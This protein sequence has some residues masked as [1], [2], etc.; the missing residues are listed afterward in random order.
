MTSWDDKRPGS[1]GSR[2]SVPRAPGFLGHPFSH[3]PGMGLSDGPV[4]QCSMGIVVGSLL[5]LSMTEA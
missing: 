5:P 3:L 2:R 4:S 1:T